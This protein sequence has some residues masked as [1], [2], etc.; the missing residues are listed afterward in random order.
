LANRFATKEGRGNHVTRKARSNPPSRVRGSP[1]VTRLSS[2]GIKNRRNIP[3]SSV[4]SHQPACQNSVRGRNKA[5]MRSVALIHLEHRHAGIG[6]HPRVDRTAR[7]P[8][9]R[10]ACPTARGIIDACEFVAQPSRLPGGWVVVSLGA[11]AS[12]APLVTAK[13]RAEPEAERFRPL[14]SDPSS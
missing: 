3:Q 2:I 5:S 7:P 11:R 12:E 4:E 14:S 6:V 9:R 8:S 13:L 1:Q 10:D